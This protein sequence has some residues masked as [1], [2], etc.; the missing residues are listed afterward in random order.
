MSETVQSLGHKLNHLWQMFRE[1]EGVLVEEGEKLVI[2]L[3]QRD[4]L[5]TEKTRLEA[6]IEGFKADNVRLQEQVGRQAETI[7]EGDKKISQLE[8]RIVAKEAVEWK[9]PPLPYRLTCQPR[10]VNLT[11]KTG[12][13]YVF[14]E[15]ASVELTF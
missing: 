6:Q 3:A 7:I 13:S 14:I 10:V 9:A 15:P 2:V 4:K 5:L 12:I 11:N 8:R 1:C